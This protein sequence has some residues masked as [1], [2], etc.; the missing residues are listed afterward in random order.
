MEGLIPEDYHDRYIDG[1]AVVHLRF[2][3]G[4]THVNA[5]ISSSPRK[6]LFQLYAGLCCCSSVCMAKLIVAKSINISFLDQTLGKVQRRKECYILVEK[7]I[8]KIHV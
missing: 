5:M 3:K 4:K 8:K 1:S 7:E 2:S 6:R